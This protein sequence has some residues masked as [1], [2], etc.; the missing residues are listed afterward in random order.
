MWL[1]RPR[2]WSDRLAWAYVPGSHHGK[3]GCI[4]IACHDGD[5]LTRGGGLG[6]FGRSAISPRVRGAAICADGRRDACPWSQRLWIGQ[7]HP[8]PTARAL[9]TAL[10]LAA[11]V[12][13][14][15]ARCTAKTRPL[16]AM[17]ARRL[18]AD[19]CTHTRAP[20]LTH[21]HTRLGHAARCFYRAAAAAIL[22][23]R[24]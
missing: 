19:R 3:L 13:L 10:A 1:S 22:P 9:T 21:T 4:S 17:R 6:C 23:P 14:H 2:P 18:R 11:V 24:P 16:G 8:Q 7:T 12:C 20:A 15:A 5:N